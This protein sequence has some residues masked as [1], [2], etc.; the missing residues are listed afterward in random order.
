MPTMTKT[1][2]Q[3]VNNTNDGNYTVRTGEQGL[4]DYLHITHWKGKDMLDYWSTDFCN[5]INGSD[6]SQYPPRLTHDSVLEIYTSEMC[7]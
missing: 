1:P 6:G 3:Q 5:M 4:D 2:C 7:R